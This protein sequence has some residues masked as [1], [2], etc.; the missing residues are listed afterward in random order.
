MY[1]E[2]LLACCLIHFRG[3]NLFGHL[4]LSKDHCAVLLARQVYMTSLTPFNVL[5]GQTSS[6]RGLQDLPMLFS[7]HQ[8]RPHGRLCN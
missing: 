5:P 1:D 6:D 7:R 8:T 4:P 2:V 3:C